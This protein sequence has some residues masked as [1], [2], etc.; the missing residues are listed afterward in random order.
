MAVSINR[1]LVSVV[2]PCYN[3]ALFLPEAIETVL[4]QTYQEFEVIVVDDGST[5]STA[6]IARAYPIRYIYQENQGLPAA[7]N[8]GIRATRGEFVVLLIL[9]TDYFRTL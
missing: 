4:Q 2:I 7:R 5:D 8:T 3:Q 6:E 1:R 9:M